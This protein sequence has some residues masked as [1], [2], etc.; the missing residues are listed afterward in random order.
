MLSGVS[1]FRLVCFFR[2]VSVLLFGV[3]NLHC[4]FDLGAFDFFKVAWLCVL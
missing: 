4:F 2:Y 3:S 1:V